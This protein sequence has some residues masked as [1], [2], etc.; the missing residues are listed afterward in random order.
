MCTLS[1]KLAGITL[2][3]DTFGSHLNSQGKVRDSE[4]AKKNFCHAGEAL[5]AL[6]NRDQIFGKPVLTQ[7]VED[8]ISHF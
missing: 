3:I 1:G 7:Y 4:L 2:P 8:N 5:Y 6:W